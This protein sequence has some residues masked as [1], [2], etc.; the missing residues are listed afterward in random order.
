M[1]DPSRKIARMARVKKIFFLRSGVRNA[2]A[3]AASTPALPFISTTLSSTGPPWGDP[4]AQDRTTLS[5]DGAE[6]R[7]P[8]RP[9]TPASRHGSGRTD[10]SRR[11]T[12]AGRPAAAAGVGK[13]VSA[14][15]AAG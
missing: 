4:N 10:D 15:Q 14:A 7:I 11:P 6:A 13:R 3:N 8:R 12:Q 5:R 9:R 1:I 2:L